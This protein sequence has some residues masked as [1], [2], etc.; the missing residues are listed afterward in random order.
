MR[1]HWLKRYH[2]PQVSRW[3]TVR[4][5]PMPNPPREIVQWLAA[6]P[7]PKP[8]MDDGRWQTVVVCDQHFYKTPWLPTPLVVVPEG[9]VTIRMLP[10]FY[11]GW[12]AAIYRDELWYMP[13]AGVSPAALYLP[14]VEQ[15]YTRRPFFL[16]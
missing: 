14:G 13:P 10:D 9:E 4:P 3:G 2:K 15:Y 11:N 8:N 12:A 1:L 7:V 5:T 6:L 16:E